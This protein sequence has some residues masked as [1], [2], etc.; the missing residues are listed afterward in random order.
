MKQ[1]LE[2]P[3]CDEGT[4]HLS[5]DK[6]KKVFFYVCDWCEEDFTTIETD[7]INYK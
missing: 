5:S 7:T 3:Y 2:C 1:T 4:A 6:D